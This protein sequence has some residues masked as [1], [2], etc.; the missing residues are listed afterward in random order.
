MSSSSLER[1]RRF[2]W[3]QKQRRPIEQWRVADVRARIS[4]LHILVDMSDEDQVRTDL[5]AE[6]SRLGRILEQQ[7]DSWYDPFDP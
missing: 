4:E 6:A 2:R 1:V 5:R 3:K 7:D